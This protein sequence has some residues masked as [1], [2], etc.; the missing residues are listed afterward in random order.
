[1]TVIPKY[2]LRSWNW[3]VCDLRNSR[4]WLLRCDIVWS[5]SSVAGVLK[6]EV[7]D[8]SEAPAANCHTSEDSDFRKLC[9]ST[10]VASSKLCRVGKVLFFFHG[11]SSRCSLHGCDFNIRVPPAWR[12]VLKSL[13]RHAAA[14]CSNNV[15]IRPEEL[16]MLD[17]YSR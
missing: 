15:M 4:W 16:G 5:L 12:A 9:S 6:M 14:F 8:S 17:P 10:L 7:A 1:M 13:T 3:C 11:T 2:V